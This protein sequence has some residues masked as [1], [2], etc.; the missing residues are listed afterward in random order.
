MVFALTVFNWVAFQRFIQG[1]KSAS[2]WK[3]LSQRT[4]KIEIA[5]SSGQYKYLQFQCLKSHSLTF[6]LWC[7]IMLHNILIESHSC[8]I[9]FCIIYL[10]IY[11]AFLQF[12]LQFHSTPNSGARGKVIAIKEAEA[13]EEICPFLRDF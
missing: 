1:Q 3:L 9:L 2:W 12:T 10:C 5:T 4:I 11:V 13:E 7:Y 8:L 6:L